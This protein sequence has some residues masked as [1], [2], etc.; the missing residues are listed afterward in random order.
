MPFAYGDMV[1]ATIKGS[2]FGQDVNT[3]L[4]YTITAANGGGDL[5]NELT[6]A[7]AIADLILEAMRPFV[8]QGVLWSLVRVKNLTAPFNTA[9]FPVNVSGTLTSNA[10]DYTA[11]F[12]AVSLTK[13]V[14]GP[15][16]NG[17]IRLPGA[18]ESVV[19]SGGYIDN[20]YRTAMAPNLVTLSSGIL[21][22]A[23]GTPQAVPYGDAVVGD[24]TL[25][26]PVVI[27]RYTV[28]Q[29][30]AGQV[31]A[32]KNVGDYDLARYAVVTSVALDDYVTTQNSRKRGRGA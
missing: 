10:E 18:S 31:P 15:T 11:P 8:V 2:Y 30:E 4:G 23:S 22:D 3:V 6:L 17:F 12:M 21:F 29:G 25:V 7:E 24:G 13:T 27:G 9:E 16:K 26:V 14:S 19:N 20:T 5:P 1:E 28:A 32:D